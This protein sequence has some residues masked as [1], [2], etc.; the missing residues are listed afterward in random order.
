MSEGRTAADAA[1]SGRTVTGA[2]GVLSRG[3]ESVVNQ[4][5]R[6]VS[7]APADYR[8]TL[9]HLQGR[10]ERHFE[11]IRDERRR[12]GRGAPVF[13]LEHGLG[14]GDL[15]VMRDA[16]REWVR[17]RRP[18]RRY[19]LPFVVHATEVGY[20]Y[21][22]DEYWPTLE[23]DTPGW[24][25]HVGRPF[26]RDRLLEFADAYG[27]ARP[28]GRWALQFNLIC[29]PITHAILPTDLQRHFARLLYDHRG[30][31]TA[32]L[33][34][35][36]ADLGVALAGR[37]GGTS[38][39]FQQFAQ[40]TDLLGQV[41]ASL[42]AGTA[43]DASILPMTLTRLV[44]DLGRERQAR[45]WLDDARISAD[46]VR[47]KGLGSTF[48]GSGILVRP[49][50]SQRP[51]SPVAFS[52][53]PTTAGWQL[54]LR[55]PD[56]SPLFARF[57]SVTEVLGQCRCR[58]AG[59]PGRPQAR[60]WLLYGGKQMQLDRWP[61]KD[62]AVFELERA[63]Q[64][65]AQLI[66]EE[67]RTPPSE[68]WLFRLGS[69]GS[70]R[71]VRSGAIQAGHRYLVVGPAVPVPAAPWVS[72]AKVACE[73]AGGVVID[74][75][76][77]IDDRVR[78][79]CD[80]MGLGLQSE[81]E[82][83]PL[84]V[85]PA[86]WDGQGYG[87]W[88]VGD[89]PLISLA[90]SHD[91][92][93]ATA[94]VDGLPSA[95]LSFENEP[96]ARVLLGLPELPAG[97]HEL[98]LSFLVAEGA[99]PL[100]DGKIEIRI[101]EPEPQRSSGSFRDPLRLVLSPPQASLEDLWD[102]RAAVEVDGPG[103]LDTRVAVRLRSSTDAADQSH[104]F[105]VRLP[106]GL[107][108]WEGVFDEQVRR[109][110]RLRDAFDASAELEIVAGDDDLGRVSLTL[111]RDL[112]PLRWGFRRRSGSHV[113]RL[114]ESAD[115]GVAPTVTYY[116]YSNAD[117]G[118]SICLPEDDLYWSSEGGLF[119]ASIDGLEVGAILPPEVREFRDLTPRVG[120]CQRGQ[121][122]RDV[123]D[124][125]FTAARWGGARVPG[126]VIARMSR[127]KVLAGVTTEL[128]VVIGGK[129]WAELERR[130]AAGQT[131]K[132]TD[133]EQ[134]LAKPGDWREF[135]A[136]VLA[137][138]GSQVDEPPV[139]ALATLL[140]PGQVSVVPTSPG[141]VVSSGARRAGLGRP[142]AKFP[143]GGRR[144]AE[145]LLRL[146]SEP[147]TLLEWDPNVVTDLVAATLDRPLVYRAARMIAVCTRRE[148]PLWRW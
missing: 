17:L 20:Q 124:L 132:P 70:G 7:A 62:T 89:R 148:E 145:F 85:V 42:L 116:P 3:R 96:Q 115:A 34:Q 128:G 123:E 43:D 28:Q 131:V 138:S 25:K 65:V 6:E 110:G 111:E 8:A 44:E 133:W 31:L 75:P 33:L 95:L 76:D 55:V 119:V 73:G 26:V 21:D 60:G 102:G 29:W 136:S 48:A 144:L 49:S 84:G 74:V 68:S 50:P 5:A 147:G 40:N 81:I 59:T 101:R 54:R 82:V 22:G 45:R 125:I 91:V 97:W 143:I 46:R 105:R 30:A 118:A 51:T 19:W 23:A 24:Q 120:F 64:T 140:G 2:P 67:A 9:D 109:E 53:H 11:S 117:K 126:D 146:A 127:D 47:R 106:V 87:E 12:A 100:A 41:A 37:V 90:T 27:G 112:T 130:H 16:V 57:P 18:A 98:R 10:L 69:D 122:T 58:V 38:K 78:E 114:Y 15:A 113:L 72:K 77:I 61:G 129:R 92:V 71:L 137:L 63:E 134:G 36:P 66:R 56:F 141:L 142:A 4:I 94:S 13:A 104:S 80:L 35:S 93:T 83:T 1:N 107:A 108:D 103:G 39:R 14:H 52:V 79:L 32:E 86:V 121:S 88:L 99:T 135:R 139:E